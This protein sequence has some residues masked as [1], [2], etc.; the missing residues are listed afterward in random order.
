MF[1]KNKKR[2]LDETNIPKNVAIIMDGNGRWANKKKMPV[3]FGHTQ[4]VKRLQDVIKYAK[5]INIQNL[6]IYAFSTE[7]WKREETEVSHLMKL[8]E[9]FYESEFKKLFD[10]NIN[11]NIIGIEDNV[12]SETKSI[13]HMI[14]TQTPSNIEMNLN[15]AFNYGS[16]KE[17]VDSVNKFIIDN[18]TS[19]IT[20][21]DIQSNLY[22]HNKED[23]DLLIRTSGEQ[24]ISNFLLWQ[25]SYSELIFTEVLWP[26][27]TKSEFEQCILEYQSR[28]RRFGGR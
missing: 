5:T 22:A 7:N 1:F 14:A 11:V 26:D 21:K 17:I 12:P 15:I 8:V 2:K 24:R 16:R 19:P 18:P 28:N 9:Q 13:L 20:E 4:G 27:F 10:N 25:I 23:I 3:S 6:T